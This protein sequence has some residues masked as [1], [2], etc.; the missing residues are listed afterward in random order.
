MFDYE[1]L[2]V[3]NLVHDMYEVQIRRVSAVVLEKMV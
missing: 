3:S 2:L 1:S